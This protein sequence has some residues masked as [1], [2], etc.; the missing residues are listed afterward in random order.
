[1]QAQLQTAGVESEH[2]SDRVPQLQHERVNL[3]RSREAPVVVQGQQAADAAE[4]DDLKVSPDYVSCGEVHGLGLPSKISLTTFDQSTSLLHLP[5][6]PAICLCCPPLC[7]APSLSQHGDVAGPADRGQ[8][9]GSRSSIVSRRG[10]GDLPY[11][12]C[13]AKAETGDLDSLGPHCPGSRAATQASRPA[14]AFLSHQIVE[15]A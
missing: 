6:Q 3:Q 13:S 12:G 7:A 10:P 8:A 5:L 15:T 1:M 11:R 2:P 4:L 14:A 9:G